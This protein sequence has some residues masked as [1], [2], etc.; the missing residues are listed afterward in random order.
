[1]R[2]S[3]SENTHPGRRR[4]PSGRRALDLRA[5]P[6]N[7][8]FRQRRDH[9]S[10]RAQRAGARFPHQD[11]R[12]VGDSPICGCGW[13]TAP[14]RPISCWSTTSAPANRPRAAPRRR[15]APWRS[16]PTPQSPTSRSRFRPMPPCPTTRSTSTR[17]GS[18]SRTRRR[19]SPRCGRPTSGAKPPVPSGRIR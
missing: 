11:R 19:C 2:E 7:P 14:R 12:R 3:H 10:D 16:T 18:R 1:M 5:D 13:S 9:L 4:G 15:S 8:V 6:R 17:C